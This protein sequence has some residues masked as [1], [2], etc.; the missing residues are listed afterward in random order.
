ML[1]TIG[2]FSSIEKVLRPLKSMHP[3]LFLSDLPQNGPINKEGTIPL[4]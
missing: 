3:I 1:T 2:W 4:Y